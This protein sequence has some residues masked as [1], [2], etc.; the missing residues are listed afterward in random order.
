MSIQ[1]NIQL[2]RKHFSLK[3][4]LSL[5][6]FG[7]TAF[8][9]PSG[10]GKSSLLRTLAGLE[11]QS[12]GYIKIGDSL[13]QDEKLFTPT[14]RR[15]IGYIFQEPSLFEHFNIRSNLEYG[16]KR[17]SNVQKKISLEQAVELLGISSLMSRMPYELSGGEQ[18]RVSIARA[19]AVCPSL[20]LMDEPLAA[21]DMERK[22]EILPYLENLHKELSIP[23]FYVSHS[24][25]EVA[26]LADHLV[27]LENG[28][29]L[30]SGPVEKVFSHLDFVTHG[31]EA[32]SLISGVIKSHDDDYRLMEVSFEGGSFIVAQKEVSLG[33]KIRLQVRSR[34]VSIT[35]KHQAETSILNIFSAVI[36]EIH[37]EGPT[38]LLIKLSIS[39]AYLLA[40]ITRK[41]ADILDLKIGKNVYAQ[42]KSVAVI[43]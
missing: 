28:K 31:D 26:R 30:T 23:I 34:D 6:S 5:P 11:P 7:V 24:R 10:C 43:E 12:K 14:H 16:Q 33:D 38:Q 3:V 40:R 42:V 8:F 29:V 25:D 15:S 9:G 35:L 17:L 39:G 37:Q 2:E 4:N 36:E 19:L 41:S 27:L 20:L 22:K 21:L 32:I 18:Q 13:W 1:M